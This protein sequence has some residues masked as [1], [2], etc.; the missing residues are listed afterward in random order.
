ML[1]QTKEITFPVTTNGYIASTQ[2]IG[3]NEDLVLNGVSLDGVAGLLL[4]GTG[5]TP[6][7][8]V[9]ITGIDMYGHER[10]ETI[11]CDPSGGSGASTYYYSTVTVANSGQI[12]AACELSY[13][14]GV[15][16]AVVYA[17]DKTRFPYEFTVATVFGTPADTAAYKIQYTFENPYEDPAAV[18]FDLTGAETT[19]IQE[20]FTIVAPH[21]RLITTAHSGTEFTVYTVQGG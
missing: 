5:L 15:A 8:T 17:P 2:A 3:A 6:N 18:W 21:L 10:T 4:W 19:Q 12:L 7:A 14:T 20:R 16:M 13:Y 11:A 1:K 9:D